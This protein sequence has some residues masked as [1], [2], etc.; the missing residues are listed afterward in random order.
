MLPAPG[1][2]RVLALATLVNTVGNGAYLACGALFLTRS[3]GLTPAELALAL[4]VSAGA[5]VLLTT[6]LGYVI[7][8]AGPRTSQ[9]TA[10][11]A[12]AVTCAAVAFVRDLATFVPLACLIAVGDAVVKAANG[13]M[14]ASA[15]PPAERIRTRAFLRSTNNAGIALGTLVAGAALLADTRA[16]YLAVLFG[17]SVTCLAAALIITRAAPARSTRAPIGGPR[18]VALRDRPFLAFAA[19]DGLVAALFNYMLTL[20]L[21]LW[22]VARTDAP[23]ALVSVV[24][25][26]NTVG[27]ITLQ[28]RA[29]RGMQTLA[30]AP[31]AIF[32]AALLVA[33][34]C[35]LFASTDAAPTWLVVV[36]A[37]TAA[38]VHVLGE[39][40]LAGASFVVVFDLAREWAHG[41]YQ[42]VYQTGRQIGNMIAPPLLTALVIGW[43]VPGWLGLAGIFAAAGL[44]A[45]RIIRSAMTT[46][47]QHSMIQSGHSRAS[48]MGFGFPPSG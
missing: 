34:S 44:I 22:L 2:P 42:A 48:T 13:A 20:A 40:R 39:L 21:P 7:D 19:L 10:L 45:P 4:S 25:L 36:L 15:V 37:L 28:V 1:T 33:A 27:C 16:A 17:N 31:P 9:I 14:T 35:V 32:R 18:M 41:Q 12:L 5:G 30:D 8:R 43:G 24:L 3:A 38:A 26:V 23:A 11:L 29:T 47:D 6:P 46:R